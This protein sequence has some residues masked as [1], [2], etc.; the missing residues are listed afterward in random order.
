MG[1]EFGTVAA[2]VVVA[3]AFALGG[4]TAGKFLRPKFPSEAKSSIYEC[5]EK[6]IGSA[7]INFNPRFYMVALIFVVFEVEIA[8][9]LPVVA[10]YKDWVAQSPM[11][12]WVAFGELLAF[13][14]FLL[15]GLAWVWVNG[16]LDWVKKVAE[17]GSQTPTERMSSAGPRKAA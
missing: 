15:I 12:G 9:T 1:Y 17:V 7:W 4:L 16:D 2:F 6:P 8:L 13:T 11:M 3:I 10:V 14:A 5:G